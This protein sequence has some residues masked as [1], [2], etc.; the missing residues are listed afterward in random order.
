MK[1]YEITKHFRKFPRRNQHNVN[2]IGK[3]QHQTRPIPT[4]KPHADND[5]L[6]PIKPNARGVKIIDDIIHRS[7]ISVGLSLRP[8]VTSRVRG[9][10]EFG[11][12]GAGRYA[13][14]LPSDLGWRFDWWRSMMVQIN[15]P[16]L[17]YTPMWVRLRCWFDINQIICLSCMLFYVCVFVTFRCIFASI[18]V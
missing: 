1:F 18:F 3:A 10:P 8:R 15:W 17:L 11:A 9:T 12:P 7:R 13:P 6:F 4:Y 14:A 16:V 5:D 2:L